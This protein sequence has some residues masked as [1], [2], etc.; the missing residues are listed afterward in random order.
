MKV[1]ASHCWYRW[2]LQPL[3]PTQSLAGVGAGEVRCYGRM[4]ALKDVSDFLLDSHAG[5][6]D[7]AL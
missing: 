7:L 5:L 2:V 6:A 4:P 3:A 1:W